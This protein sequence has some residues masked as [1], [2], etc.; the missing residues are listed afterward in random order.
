MLCYV[1]FMGAFCEDDQCPWYLPL[2][3]KKCQRDKKEKPHIDALECENYINTHP[4]E[5]DNKSADFIA[6][7]VDPDEQCILWKK[8]GKPCATVY[9]MFCGAEIKNFSAF[10]KEYTDKGPLNKKCMSSFLNVK[11][12][13]FLGDKSQFC[14]QFIENKWDS[15]GWEDGCRRL[16]YDACDGYFND[17]YDVVDLIKNLAPLPSGFVPRKPKKPK[18]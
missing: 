14:Q 11:L 1:P 10:N 3:N 2:F 4:N 13:N 15:Q 9:Y 12:P 17:G 5:F 8:A 16:T 6:E 7:N 18:T